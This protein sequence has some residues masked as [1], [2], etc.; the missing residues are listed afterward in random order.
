MRYIIIIF[1]ISLSVLVLEAVAAVSPSVSQFIGL[2]QPV[3]DERGNTLKGS[4]PFAAEEG[5]AVIKGDLVQV[6]LAPDGN[7]Y[8]PD[9]RGNPDSRNPV[10]ATS[11]IGAGVSPA[12][13]S[14]GRFSMR[15]TPRP[16][17]NTRIFVRVFNAAAAADSS[18][19][20]DSQMFT[21][22]S[23]ENRIF[24]PEI[25]STEIP[26]DT[27]DEDHDGLIG[28][29][30]KS[31][32][33]DPLMEDS[34]DDGATD[35]QEFIAGTDPLSSASAFPVITAF[36]PTG[37]GRVRMVWEPATRDRTYRFFGS[38]NE[39]VERGSASVIGAQH[40]IG[41]ENEALFNLDAMPERGFLW[42]DVSN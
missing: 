31:L 3:A 19:Y 42:F 12:L 10:L 5:Y 27:L 39:A 22:S 16:S 1:S 41:G 15:L 8:P 14:S 6:L 32:G 34:D 30:E 21:V 18:F 7:I 35:N 28:S 40:S 25:A 26:L 17:G 38:G 4:N 36:E 20:G 24:Y 37:D 2:Q 9:F 11:S 33:T 13:S 23:S 29:W